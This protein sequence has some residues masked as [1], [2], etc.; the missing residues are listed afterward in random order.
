[1]DFFM[2]TTSLTPHTY[3]H[4][5]HPPH[6]RRSPLPIQRLI[7][8]SSNMHPILLMFNGFIETF[9][10]ILISVRDDKFS[11]LLRRVVK[12][13]TDGWSL[14]LQYEKSF[15]MDVT[16]CDYILDL[17][18]MTEAPPSFPSA[19]SRAFLS[20]DFANPSPK[21]ESIAR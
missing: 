4:M 2:K 21:M 7:A 1:M 3:T 19:S 5:H 10:D 14:S 20:V 15:R 9:C 8:I 17:V 13:Q 11:L 16:G 12:E 6:T 18:A